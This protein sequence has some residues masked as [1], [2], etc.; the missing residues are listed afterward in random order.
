[1]KM[2]FK[3]TGLL[4]ISIVLIQCLLLTGAAAAEKL[5]LVVENNITGAPQLLGIPF[6]KGKL[7]SSDKVRVLNAAGQ[8]IPSQITIVNTWAPASESVKWIWVF[9][10]SE[11]SS[12]YTLEYG[13]DVVRKE[14]GGDRVVVENNQRPYGR[15]RVSTGPLRFTINRL[16]GGF[17]DKVELD[18]KRDGFDNSD[19][20]AESSKT[21]GSFL[22]IMD[23]AGIDTSRVKITHTAQEKGSGPLHAIIRIEGDYLYSRK[24]NNTSPFVMRIHA[25]AG[26][27]YIK[28]LHSIVYTGE[29]DMHP[30]QEGEY[31]AVATQSKKIIDEQKLKGASGWMVPNDRIADAGFM[32]N[33]KLDEEKKIRTGYFDGTWMNPDAE[34]KFEAG[35]AG[36]QD[37]SLLQTGPNI[38]R[39]PPLQNSTP[40]EQIT[41]FKSLLSI[42]QKEVLNK[43]RMSG[44]ITLTDKKWGVGVGIRNFFEEYPKEIAIQ[45][46]NNNLFS[47]IWSPSVDPMSFAR[48]SDQFDSEMMANFAQGLA[49]T[50]EM[51]YQFFPAETPEAN[52]TNQFKYFMDPPVSHTSPEVYANSKVYGSF[53]PRSEQNQQL[54][55]SLDYKFDWMRFNQQWEPWYGMIDYG[56]FQTY[57]IKNKWNT[58]NSGEP[59]NDYMWWMQFM[60]TGKRDY[61]ITAQATSQHTMDV[62]NIHWPA[63]PRYLG[64]T[65]NAVDYFN[66]KDGGEYTPSPLVGMG[67]RHAAQHFTSLLSAHVWVPGWIASYYLTGNHRAL[68]VAEQTGD[69]YIRKPWGEHD[70]R[71]RRLYLSVWNLSEIYDANKKGKYGK[72][73]KERVELMLELQKNTDQGGSLVIDRYGYSQVYISQ[74]LYKYYHMTG[75]EKIKEA[76]ITHAKWERD[77]P[78]INHQM[79]SFLASIHSLSVGYEFSGDKTLLNE[80]LERSKILYTDP[81]PKDFK[82]YKTQKELADALEKVSHLPD[83]KESFRGEAIWK[84][85]NGLRVF[86]W[87]HMYNVPYIL[88]WMNQKKN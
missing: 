54:E 72:E 80:A 77:N 30:K 61:Y 50:T 18:R 47:Y 41:G 37:V 42:N 4:T 70:L 43:Q 48:A 65:N 6:A 44:W 74:G 11:Q 51:V 82:S 38:S 17:L 85:T 2:N 40:T 9:F 59:A 19:L 57:Y 86:G 81:L 75:N 20:I 45:G 84:N 12:S 23:A 28:V 58:W 15:V 69:L 39:I 29:P 71:G 21:R 3:K 7:L 76:L 34:K 53:A 55:R 13:K 88:Y 63:Q 31:A 8:E 27:S 49:K 52:L 14:F 32:L 56:D 68:D 36:S 78:A 64:E 5:P 79:E 83:D 67:R 66:F 10:F 60:R 16:G 25:Y 26:K 73:L 22:D 62:D 1:M 35:L 87:T 33:Y 46:K 24:D